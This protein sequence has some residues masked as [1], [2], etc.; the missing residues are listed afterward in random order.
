LN[1]ARSALLFGLRWRTFRPVLP[2]IK[3]EETAYKS[4][5]RPNVKT[6]HSLTTISIA[7]ADGGVVGLAG[8]PWMGEID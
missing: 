3:I 8:F 4:K 6:E 5:I 7:S 1:H 2:G